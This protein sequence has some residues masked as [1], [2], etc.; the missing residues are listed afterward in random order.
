MCSG[1]AIGVLVFGR[2]RTQAAGGKVMAS[3]EFAE[4]AVNPQFLNVVAKHDLAPY[5]TRACTL[6]TTPND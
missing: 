5:G 3:A 6:N 4:S 1:A 2:S